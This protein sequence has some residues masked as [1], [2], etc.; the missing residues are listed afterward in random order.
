MGSARRDLS[1]GKL[2]AKS[3]AG[4]PC[5]ETVAE[6]GKMQDPIW[7]HG[8]GPVPDF[9]LILLVDTDGQKFDHSSRVSIGF[10]KQKSR[11]LSWFCIVIAKPE[12]TNRPPL[13]NL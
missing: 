8:S 6:N 10:Q 5:F 3:A 11:F 12:K 9:I 13:E 7:P 2:S 1:F 4:A